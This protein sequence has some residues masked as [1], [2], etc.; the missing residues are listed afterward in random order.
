MTPSEIAHNIVRNW[1]MISGPQEPKLQWLI[2]AIDGYIREAQAEQQRK[3]AEIGKKR[4][5]KFK[6]KMGVYKEDEA[7]W[8]ARY[9][10]ASDYADAILAQEE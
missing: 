2:G 9:I 10:E 5:E 7:W 1:S 6:A 8:R 3:D 4:A